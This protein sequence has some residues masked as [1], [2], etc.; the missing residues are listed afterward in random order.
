MGAEFSPK[1]C[2]NETQRLIVEVGRFH[3]FGGGNLEAA[4]Q[5]L[6]VATFGS[7]RPDECLHRKGADR[8]RKHDRCQKSSV[9]GEA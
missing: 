1:R 4:P 2:P 3:V 8:A 9:V 7:H 6:G 5:I